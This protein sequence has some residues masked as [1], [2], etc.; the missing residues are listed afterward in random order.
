M[1]WDYIIV[2][3]TTWGRKHLSMP[4]TNEN[5]KKNPTEDLL[6]MAEFVLKSN[7]FQF[8]GKI[9]QQIPGTAVAMKCST[10]ACKFMEELE[11]AFL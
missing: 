9:K 6:N 5:R 1:S 4:L 7:F 10:Y 2:F 11:R 8:N 3:H